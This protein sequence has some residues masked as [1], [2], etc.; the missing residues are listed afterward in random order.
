M[1]NVTEPFAYMHIQYASL[2]CLYS[3]NMNMLKYSI[4]VHCTLYSMPHLRLFFCR[5]CRVAETG[6]AWSHL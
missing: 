4:Y 2:I 5:H 1:K 6:A 3:M